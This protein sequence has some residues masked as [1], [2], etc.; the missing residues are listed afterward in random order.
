MTPEFTCIAFVKLSI[1][2]ESL[3]EGGALTPALLFDDLGCLPREK[4]STDSVQM[5]AKDS[6]R[7]R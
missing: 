6:K 7:C 4:G 3:A 2:L 5:P 1:P